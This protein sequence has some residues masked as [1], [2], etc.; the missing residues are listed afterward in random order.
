MYENKLRKIRLLEVRELLCCHSN[1]H[2]DHLMAGQ[3]LSY[4]QEHIP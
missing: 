3:S 2:G 4:I 1:P